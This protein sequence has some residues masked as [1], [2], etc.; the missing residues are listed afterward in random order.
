MQDLMAKLQSV[1]NDEESMKQLNELAGALSSEQPTQTPQAQSSPPT[2]FS[3]LLQGL[4]MGQTP[5]QQTVPAPAPNT[6]GID[7]AKLIQL[8]TLLAQANSKQDKNIDLLLALR[9][10]LKEENQVKIDRLVKIF[11]LFSIYPVLKES[12]LLGGDLFGLL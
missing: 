10:L 8:Q 4:G 1:L 12:G 5:S 11:K 3:Q 2:D 7:M 6:G 9:P